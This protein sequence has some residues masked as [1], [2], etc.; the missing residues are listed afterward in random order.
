MYTKRK[1][2]K[3]LSF[4]GIVVTVNPLYDAD[5]VIPCIGNVAEEKSCVNMF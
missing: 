2:E 3:S 5:Y 1:G 4:Y